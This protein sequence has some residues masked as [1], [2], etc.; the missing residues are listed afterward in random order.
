MDQE[1][2][3][4]QSEILLGYLAA[5]TTAM[6]PEVLVGSPDTLNRRIE[7]VAKAVPIDEAYLLIPQG[8]HTPDQLKDSLDLFSRKVMP[9]FG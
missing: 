1:T 8:L 4:Q 9:N 6:T 2:Q 3:T 7:A 5:N